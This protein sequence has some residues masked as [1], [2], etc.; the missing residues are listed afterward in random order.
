MDLRTVIRAVPDF[1]QPG[2]LF[3]DITP[4]LND[5]VAFAAA[6]DGL[7]DLI[8]DVEFDRFAA[9]ESRG[10]LFGAPLGLRLEKG[11]VMLRKPGKLPADVIAESYALEYGATTLE[12]H[13]DAIAPG[14]RVLIVDDLLATGG[15]AAASGRLVRR[16]GGT[17]AGYLFLVS[18]EDLGGARHLD[19]AP[20]FSLV[21][22]GAGR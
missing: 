14:E 17:V 8:A 12:V 7:A 3:R 2:I 15:T 4:V 16:L 9:M 22:Y 1:P 11:L 19:D 18:L 20:V 6:I 10:F 5:P 21:K 13:R